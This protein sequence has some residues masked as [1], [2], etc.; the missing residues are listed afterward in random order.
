[1]FR[2]IVVSVDGTGG[3]DRGLD[4]AIGLA[5]AHKARL[6]LIAGNRGP[7]PAGFLYVS[8]FA[9]NA[10]REAPDDCAQRALAAG[11]ARV[12]SS[13]AVTTVLSL[14]SLTA[15]LVEEAESDGHD[16]IVVGTGG[17]GTVL[18]SLRHRTDGRAQNPHSCPTPS[19]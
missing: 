2:S 16:L 3:S 15:A 14:R 19:R 6:K 12:P 17:R 18:P 11:E 9:I 1:V 5:V 10:P 4:L 13:V 7:F 8:E